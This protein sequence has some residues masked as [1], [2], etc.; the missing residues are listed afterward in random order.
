MVT[1]ETSA[2]SRI[3]PEMIY[4]EIKSERLRAKKV[5]RYRIGRLANAVTILL[6]GIGVLV[7]VIALC[8]D[9][10]TIPLGFVG[11]IATWVMAVPLRAYFVQSVPQD[12][13][14]C[15]PEP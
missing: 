12:E 3:D 10:V 15:E 5:Y 2:R 1:M 11:W 14:D 8:T 7:F 13:V 9:L 6:F 4:K